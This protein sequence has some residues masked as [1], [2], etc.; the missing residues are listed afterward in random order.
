MRVE[1]IVILVSGVVVTPEARDLVRHE[2]NQRTWD[3]ED[4][5]D[6]V[7]V[8]VNPTMLSETLAVI[9]LTESVARAFRLRNKT[10]HLCPCESEER[11]TW[12]GCRCESYYAV[13]NTSSLNPHR[14]P[15]GCF[16]WEK[17]PWTCVHAKAR[18]VIMGWVPVWMLL[19]VYYESLK[20]ELKTLL[21]FKTLMLLCC[22]KH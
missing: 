20:R 1:I 2:R 6:G 12:G 9:R 8:G 7:G 21:L 5:E 13:R 14:L 19:V 18:S 17:N 22:Q 16:G 15:P 3:S 4:R 10:M 11:D